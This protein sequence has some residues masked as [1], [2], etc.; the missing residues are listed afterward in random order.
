[1]SSRNA[2]LVQH[3]LKSIPHPK[4]RKID[5][6][7]RQ[8]RHNYKLEANKD[9]RK[10]L[11]ALT[12][13]RFYWFRC[14]LQTLASQPDSFYTPEVLE[15]LIQMHIE[16]NVQE[17]A[18]MKK[19]KKRVQ[20]GRIN[21]LEEQMKYESQL[22]ATK[23]LPAPDITDKEIREI[24][25]E[26]WDGDGRTVNCVPMSNVVRKNYP[27]VTSIK[28]QLAT[29]LQSI[30]EVRDQQEAQGVVNSKSAQ[31]RA[32][33]AVQ[34]T[35]A[36]EALKVSVKAVSGDQV[37]KAGTERRIMQAK[38]RQQLKRHLALSKSRGLM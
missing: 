35:K 10:S 13:A 6:L 24:M 33:S 8:M 34:R 7:Q 22:F 19:E 15:A 37:A 4:D 12:A 9:K 38:K 31:F 36:L 11:D 25:L 21:Y 2:K 17:I 20:T 23:G 27:N 5:Q 1:M 28:N 16:R 18:D 32:E 29:M 3:K 26:I 30:D 14:Q